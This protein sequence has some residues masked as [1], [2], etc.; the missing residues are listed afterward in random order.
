M[1][2]EQQREIRDISRAGGA[3]AH[4][5]PQ[6]PPVPHSARAREREIISPPR[7]HGPRALKRFPEIRGFAFEK[8]HPFLR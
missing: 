3:R 4:T 5:A 8:T 2:C 1:V 7:T 6:A